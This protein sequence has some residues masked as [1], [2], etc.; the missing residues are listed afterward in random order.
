VHLGLMLLALG[1]QKPAATP[2]DLQGVWRSSSPLYADRFMEFYEGLLIFGTG[3][4]GEDVN[5]VQQV[6]Q[7]SLTE[8]MV[9]Y[10]I[11]YRDQQ[12]E[13]WTL[14]LTFSPEQGGTLQLPNRAERWHMAHKDRV[15]NDM[16][17]RNCL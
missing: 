8:Q 11:E 1:C 14:R 15:I 2:K 3:N 17:Q 7:E 13:T 16:V 12:G 6:A 4:C 5:F 9:Q 10:H